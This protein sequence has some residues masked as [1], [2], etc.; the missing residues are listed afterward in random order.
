MSNLH[1]LYEL[2][3]LITSKG[4]NHA[5]VRAAVQRLDRM[6]KSRRAEATYACQQRSQTCNQYTAGVVIRYMTKLSRHYQSMLSAPTNRANSTEPYGPDVDGF[7]VW[8]HL[9]HNLAVTYEAVAECWH[10]IAGQQESDKLA[11]ATAASKAGKQR[12]LQATVN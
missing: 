4:I 9:Q 7:Q 11:V 2:C 1:D 3:G 6:D 12:C 10:E 5:N 8:R